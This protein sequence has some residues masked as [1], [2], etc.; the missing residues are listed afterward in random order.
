[1]MEAFLGGDELSVMWDD[2]NVFAVDRWEAD[3]IRNHFT[4]FPTRTMERASASLDGLEA[5]TFVN[6][7]TGQASLDDFDTFVSDW[8]SGGGDAI[9]GEVNDW[10]QGQ[11]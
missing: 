11:M 1:M 10:W 7:I 8:R 9:T 6:I 4:T 2:A 3:G 5:E